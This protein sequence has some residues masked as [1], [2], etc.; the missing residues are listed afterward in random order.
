M[1]PNQPGPSNL[2]KR[3]RPVSSFGSK[4]KIPRTRKCT[5]IK[6]LKSAN[7]K[8]PLYGAAVLENAVK[9]AGPYILGPVLGPSPVK[10]IVQCLARK[11]KT[12]D[13]YQIKILTLTEDAHESQDERQGKMLLHTEFSLLS[14]LH[15]QDGVIH[16]HGLFKDHSFEEMP[17]PEGRG[18]VYTGRVQE[19]YFLV[20]DNVIAHN[21]SEKG[22]DLINLQQYVTKVKK[23]PER[24]AVLIFYDIVRVVSKLHQR[25][26]VHRDLKLGNIVLNQRTGRIII[27]NFCL[28]THL[29]SE[30]DLLKDQRGSP[31]Y[32]SPD[33]LLCKPYLGQPSDM[34]ALGVILYTM[35]YGQF[36]FCDTSLA[37]LF[38]RIQAANYNIPPDGNNVKVSAS[39]VFLIQR[40]L[41]KDPKHRLLADE[42]LD[43]LSSIIASYITIPKTPEDLQV[44]PQMPVKEKKDRDNTKKDMDCDDRDDAGVLNVP[45]D[46]YGP[47]VITTNPT[48]GVPQDSAVPPDQMRPENQSVPRHPIVQRIG[49][50]ARP[51]L[52]SEVQRYQNILYNNAARSADHSFTQLIQQ[53]N[54][55]P[56]NSRLRSLAQRMPRLNTE[57]PSASRDSSGSS[58]S[59]SDH[60]FRPIPWSDNLDNNLQEQ[61]NDLQMR[62]DR[63]G[64]DNDNSE[65]DF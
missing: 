2:G 57:V 1:D 30:T 38:T 55:V 44:V 20:L 45:H 33:V 60:G 41:V 65:I 63:N 50:D 17:N 49:R 43:Q 18:F 47:K 21:F 4:A 35:L 34:W 24:D 46:L 28:G 29:G 40:L 42:V 32:V 14:M 51:L 12:D 58:G 62:V 61:N 56:E 15:D 59:G 22:S 9:K 26:I 3:T 54:R 36:P 8:T 25:N 23:V 16:H 13:F 64:H 7:L 5:F 27:T 6:T 53:D 52:P 31:A 10:S 39:T 19:R 37:Q 11:E 48:Q